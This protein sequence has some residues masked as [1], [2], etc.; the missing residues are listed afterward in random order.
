MC[1]PS[2]GESSVSVAGVAPNRVGC[3]GSRRAP[4]DV[5]VVHLEQSRRDR[6]RI[7]EKC[8]RREDHRERDA[9]GFEALGCIG[10]GRFGRV[11]V[12]PV[13]ESLDQLAVRAPFRDRRDAWVVVAVDAKRPCTCRRSRGRT[14]ASR[15]PSRRQSGTVGSRRR[16]SSSATRRIRAAPRSRPSRPR[17]TKRPR[18]SSTTRRAGRHGRWRAANSAAVIACAANSAVTL[19]A[20]V[21]RRNTGTPS[22]GSAWFVAKP[23]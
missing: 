12:A 13:H 6:V 2:A 5:M 8:L 23:P 15:S 20:A 9:L 17:G 16:S 21:W 11:G 4:D 7:V 3:R 1:S 19:S 22:A 10:H 14:S 18:P